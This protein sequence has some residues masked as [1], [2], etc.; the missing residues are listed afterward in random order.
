MITL[1]ELGQRLRCA[2]DEAGYTQ[3]EAGAAL[4]LDATAIAKIERGKRGVGALELKALASL[5]GVSVETM[6]EE[7]SPEEEVELVVALR[8]VGTVASPRT[9][10][11][12]RRLQRVISDDRWLRG[13]EPHVRDQAWEPLPE[14]RSKAVASYDLGYRA[15]DKFRGRYQLGDSP[16]A[17]LTVLADEIGVVVIHLPLGDPNSPDGCSAV[18]PKTGAAYALINSDKPWARRRFTLAHEIGHLVM[19][20]VASGQIVIDESVGSTDSR[21]TEANGFAAGLL[22]PA[23]GVTGILHRLTT[24]LGDDAAPLAW[25]VWI[26]AAFGVSEEAA[27]YRLLNLGLQGQVGGDPREAIKALMLNPGLLQRT[28]MEL[29]LAP[30][31]PDSERGVTDIGPSMM[32]RVARA[33]ENGAITVEGAAAMLHVSP[34]GAY[35]WVVETGIRPAAVEAPL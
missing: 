12:Q 7:S 23:E 20:H 26:A 11:M 15:A 21:E 28:R 27:A 22:M 17:D 1:E 33:L 16:I 30:V 3:E 31:E 8:A 32:S 25:V 10:A 13:G 4:G 14:D 2:R 29:G 18:D 9:D 34:E 24:R 19:G 6:L 35:R 5:Y